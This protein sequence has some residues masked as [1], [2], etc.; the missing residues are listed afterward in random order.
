MQRATAS[1]EHEHRTIE[2]IVR[3]TGVLVDEL[4]E[5]RDIDDDILRDLCQ[6]LRVYGHQ[7]H[8]GK[9]ESYLFPMLERHGVP[10]EGCPLGALRHEHERSRVLTQ[11]LVQAS[12]EY[13]ANRHDGSATLSEVLRNIAQFYPAH[14][15]KEE[16]LLFPMARKVLSEEDDQLSFIKTKCRRVFDAGGPFTGQQGFARR[17]LRPL[18]ASQKRVEEAR[19]PGS[20]RESPSDP[21]SERV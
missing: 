15:W 2:K 21:D 5:N 20:G 9:E 14:I 19:L 6:F 3:V 4:A 12:A 10:E 18:C 8:H 16:Y 1:L 13:A 7:C 11:E 17:G